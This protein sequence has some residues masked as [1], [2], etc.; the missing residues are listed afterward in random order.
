MYKTLSFVT[1]ISLI[2]S[3]CSTKG[4]HEVN[5][6]IDLAP[7]VGTIIALPLANNLLARNAISSN[8]DHLDSTDALLSS[9]KAPYYKLTFKNKEIWAYRKIV[10]YYGNTDVT[11]DIFFLIEGKKIIH[12]YLNLEEVPNYKLFKKDENYIDPLKKYRE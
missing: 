1:L 8:Y 4:I 10:T 3:A 5:S 7:S 9:L 12:Y 6:N 11:H 2:L